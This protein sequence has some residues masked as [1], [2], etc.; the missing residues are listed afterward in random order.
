[1]AVLKIEAWEIGQ[2]WTAAIGEGQKSGCGKS[3]GGR[4]NAREKCSF[5]GNS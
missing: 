3:G 5:V 2:G 1:M 4:G